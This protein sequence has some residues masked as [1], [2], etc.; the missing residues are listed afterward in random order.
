LNF[1]QILTTE[2]AESFLQYGTWNSRYGPVSIAI[3]W[4]LCRGGT[5]KWYKHISRSY[6]AGCQFFI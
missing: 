3:R 6:K 1:F 5:L 4:R 2:A